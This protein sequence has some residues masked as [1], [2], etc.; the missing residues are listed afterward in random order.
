MTCTLCGL[1]STITTSCQHCF[2]IECLQQ[3][4]S[5]QDFKLQC[6][7]CSHSLGKVCDIGGK[8]LIGV[9][10]PHSWIACY[11]LLSSNKLE[12]VCTRLK[13]IKSINMRS[14]I[15]VS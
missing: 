1:G 2:H 9:D 15:V 13:K 12:K 10:T 7:T 3:Y 8:Y 4:W 11:T 5:Q 14:H 6:P